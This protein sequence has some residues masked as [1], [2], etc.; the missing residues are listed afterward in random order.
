V[1]RFAVTTMERSVVEMMEGHGMDELGMLVPHQVNQR[2]IDAAV[3]K[4]EIP[5][6]RVMVNIQKY[7]N[8]SAASV[9][10]ALDEAARAG[11]LESG[12]L[13]VMVAFGAGLNW[14]GALVRW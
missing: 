10:I 1:Y 12:K 8:T 14:G 2:I 6:E 3:E 4:L 5:V 13:V 7:G 9:P 11:R